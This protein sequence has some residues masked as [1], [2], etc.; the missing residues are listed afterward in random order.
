M[1]RGGVLNPLGFVLR[2]MRLYGHFYTAVCHFTCRK[3]LIG[4]SLTCLFSS[5]TLKSDRHLIHFIL[6][7]DAERL[8]KFSLCLSSSDWTSQ[9]CMPKQMFPF[10]DMNFGS[11]LSHY[12]LRCYLISF[13]LVFSG[14]HDHLQIIEEG[15]AELRL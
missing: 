13:I 1:Q 11:L 2:I 12:P 15:L 6:G 14:L 3:E 9:I 5:W 8:L 7:K 10:S 4:S